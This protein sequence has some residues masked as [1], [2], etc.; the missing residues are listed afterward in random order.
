MNSFAAVPTTLSISLC[1]LLGGMASARAQTAAP[2]AT[3]ATNTRELATAR[4]DLARAARR[5][6]DLSRGKAGIAPEV[7]IQRQ[8]IRKPVIGVL[9]APDEQ[10]GVRIAG[11]TPDGGAAKAG[12]KTG[13]RIVSVN[14]QQI[15][16]SNSQLRVA[17]TRTL[18]GKLEA[19]EP[20]KI[21]YARDGRTAMVGVTPQIDEHVFVWN[22]GDGGP[23]KAGS[24]MVVPQGEAGVFAFNSDD[25]DFDF[26][27]D[28]M[29]TGI[30]P[31]IRKEILRIG[32]NGSCKGNACRAP[33]LMSAFRWNG[34]N[35][36]SVDA[37]LGR[38]FGTDRGV[39]VLSNG[40]LNGLQAGDVIQRIDGKPVANPR[41]A[42]AALRGKPDGAK[43][44]IDYLRDRRT[45]NTQVT[46]PK[47]MPLPIPPAPPAPPAPPPS[48]KT[49]LAPEPA[50]LIRFA[51]LASM[52]TPPAPP[53]PLA[54]VD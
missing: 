29:A 34:L 50:S 54:E 43:V 44:A 39:L 20:T 35:L 10:S 2:R 45:G 38:Y 49:A 26:D 11:V 17:N 42:M 51:T 36:A 24:R 37:Q 16:G 9:L 28:A 7:R 25:F 48:P 6:A 18:L 1:L 40:E 14:G 41:E 53:A 13:D 47:L 19:G 5:V 46:V 3:E 21:G 52:P 12:L 15:L 27:T 30:A 31:E 22:G 23:T 4:A 8:V 33:M 32:P